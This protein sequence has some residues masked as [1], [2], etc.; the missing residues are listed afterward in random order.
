M[1]RLFNIAD[2]T[3]ISSL[4]TAKIP[5]LLA[6]PNELKQKIISYVRESG[7]TLTNGQ[8]YPHPTL[9]TLRRVHCTFRQLIPY[10]PFFHALGRWDFRQLQAAECNV[11]N[12]LPVWFFPCYG[13]RSVLYYPDFDSENS[14]R[15]RSVGGQHSLL[16]RCKS[17]DG[18]EK[19]ALALALA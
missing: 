11:L 3:S 10:D 12:P 15:L 9:M 17:C 4:S 16:R 18:R 19:K 14:S 8:F 5:P 1:R 6:L 7:Y 2:P 13:C